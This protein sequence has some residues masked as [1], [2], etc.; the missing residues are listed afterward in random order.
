MDLLGNVSVAS[1][2]FM[3]IAA[4]CAGFIDAI[5]GGGGLIQLPALLIGL[6][7]SSTVQVLGTNKLSAIFGTSA[8]AFM[9]R[10]RARLDLFLTLSMAS[11]A[12]VGSMSGALLASN[13]PTKAFRP[14]VFIL[15]IAVGVFTWKR[16]VLGHVEKMRHGV[17][18]R[19]VIAILV[20]AGIG[21]YDGIFGPG[22]GTFLMLV[23]VAVLGYEFL[24]ASAIAKVVNVA[25]NAGAIFIFGIHGVVLWKIGLLLGIANITGGAL[26]ARM[27]LRGGSVFIRKIFLMVT[28]LLIIKVGIDTITHW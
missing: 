15:L 9:Y 18:R 12:L 3:G 22:T 28:A 23:L 24:S 20:G 14:L 11:A 7:Q 26:G 19:R 6:P 8:A 10:K 13:I 21:F 4:L 27:A 2:V 17:R 16:P 1:M 25:T 5:A